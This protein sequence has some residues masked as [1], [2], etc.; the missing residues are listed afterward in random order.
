MFRFKNNPDDFCTVQRQ[1]VPQRLHQYHPVVEAGRPWRPNGLLRTEASSCH[2]LL[3]TG[4]P[5][6]TSSAGLPPRG[7]L[8]HRAVLGTDG[9]KHGTRGL[10]GWPGTALQ[11]AAHL[12]V[13]DLGV[14]VRIGRQDSPQ[15]CD[16]RF[17]LEGRVLRQGAVQVPLYL[18]RHQAALSHGLL[19]QVAVVTGMR[20]KVRDGIWWFTSNISML[21]GNLDGR[22]A[23]ERM[24]TCVCMAESSAVHLKLSQ[25]C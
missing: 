15:C 13:P 3:G 9:E 8:P 10:G 11:H 19:H 22:G 21:C 5:P 1:D 6:P 25:H 24:D 12:A 16:A 4:N 7:W 17:V 2:A 20:G 18:L 23:W 14:P